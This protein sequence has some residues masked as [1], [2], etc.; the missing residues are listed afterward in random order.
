[1]PSENEAISVSDLIHQINASLLKHR[2]RV[3]G[4]IT[5]VDFYPKAVYFSVRD[6]TE[7]AVLSCMIWKSDYAR[8][9]V[10]LA[11]GM[12][13]IVSG[14]PEIYAPRG[15]FT[16]KVQTIE[17]FGEGKLK[18]EYEL[19]KKKLTEEGLFAIEKKKKI[20]AYARNIG[21]IT[22]KSGV[23]LRD[24]L[25]NVGSHGFKIIHIDSRVE[26]K[27]ALHELHQAL[28]T[29]AKQDIDVLVIVKGGGAL[30]SFQ[31]FNNESFVRALAKFPFPVIT[32]I[33]HQPDITLAQLVADH[34]ADTPTAAAQKL[35]EEWSRVS[36][37]L[38][39][40]E[41]KII[42]RYA[43][44]LSL[45]REVILNASATVM[46]AFN[47]FERV[48]RDLRKD[49]QGAIAVMR[50]MLNKHTDTVG[51]TLDRLKNLLRQG[52][53]RKNAILREVSEKISR[54]Q[55]SVLYTASVGLSEY[56]EEIPQLLLPVFN[57]ISSD[58]SIGSETIGRVFRPAL[59]AA[60]ANMRSYEAQIDARNP[61]NNL[62]LGYSIAYAGG[63]LLRDAAQL[64]TGEITEVRL[65]KGSF[66][67]KVE[68]ITK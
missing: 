63:K 3:H 19:L 40:A 20:P 36:A 2:A 66:T 35:N 38:R 46:D 45:N 57:G 68:N 34:G 58:L 41:N 43:R 42:G 8:N 17:L 28:E 64:K 4:E 25:M 37:I 10:E 15:S 62:K 61:E 54:S 27:D 48:I 39:S 52:I 59:A 50:A 56:I 32:G 53:G 13:V 60:T 1:M 5:K 11:A 47:R 44:E 31:A 21:I 23:V 65:L 49:I 51:K 12:E 33:G 9:A 26:G 30:E 7:D 67:S 22:S 29:M 24:F 55:S 6:K 18:Q 16:L 14:V